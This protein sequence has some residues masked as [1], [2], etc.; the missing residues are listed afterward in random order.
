MDLA[1]SGLHAGLQSVLD[2]ALDA[3]IVMDIE[4]Q[5]L[6]WNEHAEAC[7]GWSADESIGRRL[8]ELIIPP[9]HRA[10]HERGLRRFLETGVGPVLDRHIEISGLHRDGHELPVELS[11]TKTDQFGQRLFIGFIRDISTRREAAERQQRL[12]REFNHRLKNLLSVVLALAHQT[13]RN[14]P[15]IDS[16]QHA[17]VG[18][19]ETL[20]RGHD[21]LVASEWK[22][23]DLK[24][25]A[26]QILGADVAADRTSLSGEAVHLSAKQVIGLALILHEL[27]TNA[28]KYGAL[29]KPAG[30]IDIHWHIEGGQGILCWR[31]GGLEGIEKPSSHGF[32]QQL[33]ALTAKADLQGNVEF[34]WRSEGLMA[35]I[36]FALPARPLEAPA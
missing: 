27:Y 6:G 35:T 18:R 7:F 15:D 20:A 24:A 10:A 2:T 1:R 21:L 30:R 33:I 4:G 31:E 25:L 11:I 16:F 23:V 12:L 32:G 22:E 17:F 9:Q 5:V 29:A 36:R 28:L 8:S 26:T 34:D 19:L 3:V 14:S 13:A